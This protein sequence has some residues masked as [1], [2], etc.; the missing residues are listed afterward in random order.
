MII[1][2]MYNFITFTLVFVFIILLNTV[3]QL[4]IYVESL[5]DAS[6]GFVE[7]HFSL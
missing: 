1:M 3:H 4:K 5:H 2:Y 7:M 6:L